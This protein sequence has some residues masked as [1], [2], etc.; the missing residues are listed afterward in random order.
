M[1]QE[2]YGNIDTSH[3]ETAVEIVSRIR[4][5]EADL[6]HLQNQCETVLEAKKEV[7]DLSRYT[8]ASNRQW[9]S[10]LFRQIAHVRQLQLG[11]NDKP[12]VNS[13]VHDQ[14]EVDIA[15]DMSDT[16][17]SS[18]AD[19]YRNKHHINRTMSSD[20]ILS[21]QSHI[22]MQQNVMRTPG[23]QQIVPAKIWNTWTH[24]K[25]TCKI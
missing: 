1:E 16:F 23:R 22:V 3:D 4:Q 10:A 9:I 15:L 12:E 8:M 13:L 25:Y 24:R 21:P 2:Q 20:A 18:Y 19:Y 17:A 5:L 7:L 6:T 11:S 14:T